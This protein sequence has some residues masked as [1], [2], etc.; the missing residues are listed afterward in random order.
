MYVIIIGGQAYPLQIFPGMEVSS[1]F[2][3]GQTGNYTA[4]PAEILLGI[5]GVGIA[6]AAATFAI[7]ILPFLPQSLANEVVDPHST[8]SA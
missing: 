6:L 4:T 2:G 5:G 3:D 8:P 7:K 1:S